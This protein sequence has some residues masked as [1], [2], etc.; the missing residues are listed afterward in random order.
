MAVADLCDFFEPAPA[1]YD[2]HFDLLADPIAQVA[3]A[4]DWFLP[5]RN[6][7]ET[8]AAAEPGQRPQF[9]TRASSPKQSRAYQPNGE[10]T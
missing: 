9:S 8:T 6:E 7:V 5:S 10:K 2:P 4:K 1:S 3:R